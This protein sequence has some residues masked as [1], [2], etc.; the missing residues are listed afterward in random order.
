MGVSRKLLTDVMY[1]QQAV[2]SADNPTTRYC[3]SQDEVRL[4]NVMTVERAG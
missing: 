2:K 1:S 3:L 4:Y